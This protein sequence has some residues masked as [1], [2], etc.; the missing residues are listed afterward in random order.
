MER[1]TTSVISAIRPFQCSLERV[2][3]MESGNNKHGVTL[4]EIL[5]VVAVIVILAGL[6]AGIGTAIDSYSKGKALEGTFALL[7]A[8]LDEYKDFKK[9]FPP[10][11]N[12]NSKVFNC[13]ELY[14]EL[15]SVPTSAEIL[16]RINEKVI[17][18]DKIAPAR[19]GLYEIYD[20]WGMVLDYTYNPGDSYPRL[21]SAGPDSIF[22]NGDDIS[23][24]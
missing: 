20:P 10:P 3:K 7:E 16:E 17:K 8:A 13:E 1:K 22:N 6:T 2:Y 4:V 23:N 18:D 11:A 24:R 15:G 9:Y 5:V 14:R 21:T 12:T 19:E